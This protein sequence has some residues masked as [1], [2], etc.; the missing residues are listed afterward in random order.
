[1][2]QSLVGNFRYFGPC[3]AGYSGAGLWWRFFN[4]RFGGAET[5]SIADR[6]RFAGRPS[7]LAAAPFGRIGAGIASASTV[8]LTSPARAVAWL[9]WIRVALLHLAERKKNPD[10]STVQRE[11]TLQ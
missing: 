10:N 11:R 1:M 8:H 4:F 3:G 7:T 5:G 9:R 6:E 2:P